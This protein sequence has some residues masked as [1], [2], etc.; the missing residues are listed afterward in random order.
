MLPLLRHDIEPV[1]VEVDGEELI[2]LRD[3][4]QFAERSVVV[5]PGA[6]HV[7]GYLDGTHD[8]EGIRADLARRGAGTVTLSDI[9]AIVESLDDCMLLDNLHFRRAVA[10][11]T[12]EFSEAA[13]RPAAHAGAAYPAEPKE[14]ALFLQ[15]MLDGVEPEK[16]APLTRLIA[17]H[18]DLRLGARIHARAHARLHASGRPDAVIVLGVCHPASRGRFIL[19]TKDF[20][21]PLGTVACDQPLADALQERL[22]DLTE[23]Q[24]VHRNEHSIEF[25]ALWLAHLWP[26]DPPAILPIL[27]GSFS[28]LSE[29]G[30]SPS[31]DPGIEQFIEALAAIL[32]D[33]PRRIVTLASVDL[34]HIGPIYGHEKG[35][36]EPG[37]Q[38]LADLDMALLERIEAGDAEGFFEELAQDSN[39]RNV[40]GLAPIYLT[41]RLGTG[42]G[43][44]LE[45]GQGRIEPRSGS[46]VSFAAL[47]FES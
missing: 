14:A 18:I 40:C 3:P 46:V 13:E 23:E 45:Y 47:A 15:E 27:V 34:S 2:A 29:S 9:E 17:P 26:H 39:A 43:A 32:A 33:D 36:D 25:Q 6:L 8:L 16:P 22:G 38:E 41:L 37:E 5:P 20:E 4:L 11:R 10:K 35:L 30:R 12:L 42:T 19:C 7:L 44:L 21:T 1:P 28:D 31:D 24:L